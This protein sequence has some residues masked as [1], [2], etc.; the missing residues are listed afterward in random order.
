MSSLLVAL[1][2]SNLLEE[3]EALLLLNKLKIN[4]YFYNAIR[5]GI[6]FCTTL[7][8]LDTPSPLYRSAGSK[9]KLYNYISF[10]IGSDYFRYLFIELE[11][12]LIG[13]VLGHSRTQMRLRVKRQEL[14]ETTGV[15]L[16]VARPT[17]TPCANVIRPP[18]LYILLA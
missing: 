17:G 18:H 16:V 15:R 6:I 14:A 1:N 11:H 2:S 4:K 8:K 10:S 5:Y 3:F 7:D 13:A 12:K 9:S